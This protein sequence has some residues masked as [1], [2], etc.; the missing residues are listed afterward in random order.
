MY[1]VRLPRWSLL[2]FSGR[3]TVHKAVR[4]AKTINFAMNAMSLRQRRPS[5]SFGFAAGACA[6]DMPERSDSLVQFQRV[7]GAIIGALATSERREPSPW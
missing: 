6:D 3:H 7:R 1:D 2:D 4:I 5:G